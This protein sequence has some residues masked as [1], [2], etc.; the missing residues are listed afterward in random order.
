MLVNTHKLKIA[1]LLLLIGVMNLPLQAEEWTL[2][3]CIDTAQVKNKMLLMSKTTVAIG[4][5]RH[6]E[7]VAGLI[8]KLTVNGDYKYYID[9]PYQLM[10]LSTFNPTAPAG[11]FKEAQFGVPHNLNLNVQFAMPLFNAQILGGMKTT[12]I[13]AEMSELQQKRTEEQVFFDISN[14]YYNAQILQKQK[15][16]IDSNLLNTNKLLQNMQLLHTQDMLK[17]SDV[18]K[19]EL[20]KAQLQTQLQLVDSKLV[21]VLNALK[22]SMGIPIT[23]EIAINQAIEFKNNADFVSQKSVDIQL[24]E[25]HNLFLKSELSTL[26]NSRLPSLLLYGTYGQTGFGYDEKPNDFLKFFPVSFVGVQ[27]SYPLF[28]GTVTQRKINQKKLEIS[29][30]KLQVDLATEQNNMLTDNAKRTKLTAQQTVENTLAQIKLSETVYNQ[31]VLQQKQGTAS[32]TDILLADNSLR[33][34]QQNYLSAVVEFL[35]AELELK[36][37]T[38]NLSVN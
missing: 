11:Q 38:G 3:Q 13:G 2:E 5:Q 19:V 17:E 26:K 30:S 32:L 10:P 27:L 34:S 12:K 28:T 4:E 1:F 15:A 7:A 37:L 33:E 25:K 9:L 16:F 21:Q 22:F 8:P 18:T 14:L 29:N 20:Q 23:Q 35:K 6:K 36:K 24:V 31:V